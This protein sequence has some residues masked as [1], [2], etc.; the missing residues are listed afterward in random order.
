LKVAVDA[1]GGDFAPVEVVLGAV[2]AKKEYGIDIV[3][4]G[5]EE[6]LRKLDCFDPE[7]EVV[8]A[9]LTIGMNDK[10]VTRDLTNSIGRGIMLVKE[11]RADAFVS[12]G[13]T[14]AVMST[15]IIQLKKIAGIERPAIPTPIPHE[16]GES[17]LIDA[18]ANVTAKSEHML[19]FAIMGS[20]YAHQIL[21]KEN[22]RV[23]LLSNGAEEHK[24]SPLV[25]ETRELIKKSNLNFI[26]NVEGHDLFN[27]SVDVVVCD[28]FVGN[29]VL[30][31]AE[32]MAQMLL[33]WVHEE[34]AMARGMDGEALT[35]HMKKIRSRMDYSTYG[36]APLLG[37]NGTCI[38]C[39]GRSKAPA[40]ANAI[41]LA[42]DFCEKDIQS[43]IKENVA[44]LVEAAD[45]ALA[46]DR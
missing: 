8:H 12:A 10:A 4:V 16:T 36:G 18:G 39:H 14:G 32:G 5:N 19:H 45:G 3:L 26:G 9:P 23:G 37:I 2:K 30:K 24:G 25:H 27:G 7:I 1:M 29:A 42:K 41:K 11:G 17:V 33:G 46:K 34:F 38:I 22:P 35:G 31:V 20:I 40:I 21:G 15:A 6:V 44:Q 13:H 28:G 43:K